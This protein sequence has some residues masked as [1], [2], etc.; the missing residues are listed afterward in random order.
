[1]PDIKHFDPD[2]ALDRAVQLFWRQGMAS[3]GIQDVVTATGVNR[4]SLYATFGSKRELYLTVLRRYLE[5]RSQPVFRRLIEDE[6]GMPAI[7]EFFAELIEARCSGKYAQWGCM[8][9]NAHAGTENTDPEIRTV[10]E[11]HHQRL[12]DA[13]HA[14]LVRADAHRQL[15]PGTDPDSAADL[16]ALLAYGVNLRSRAGAD[17]RALHRTVATALNSIAM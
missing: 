16:L 17:A 7:T 8:V 6:R 13:M 4:S 11:Q 3:T 15:T 1:M 2:A 5:N 14:A 10:L 12:R 9:S